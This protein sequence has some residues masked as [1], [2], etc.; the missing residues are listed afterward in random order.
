[1]NARLT[2]GWAADAGLD[3]LKVAA[4]PLSCRDSASP[5]GSVGVRWALDIRVAPDAVGIEPTCG[6]AP[7]RLPLAAQPWGEVFV[8][9]EV[10][11]VASVGICRPHDDRLQDAVPAN[12]LG[13]FLQLGLRKLGARVVRVLKSRLR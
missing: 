8:T 13:Q 10:N 6:A 3:G 9:A 12:V 1:L 7:L 5:Y 2:H 11:E 4:A